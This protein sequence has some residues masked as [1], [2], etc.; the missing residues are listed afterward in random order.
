M[1]KS[2]FFYVNIRSYLANDS[3]VKELNEILDGYE[4]PLNEDVE[5]FLKYTAVEFAERNQSVSYLVFSTEDGALLG[6]F[7]IAIKA[8]TVRI[9]AISNTVS[10]KLSRI[11]DYDTETSSYTIPAFLIAQLG[12][13]YADGMNKRIEGSELLEM[14]WSVIKET[15]YAVGGIVAFLEAENNNELLNFYSV[16]NNFRKFDVRGSSSTGKELVQLLKLL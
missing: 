16:K 5:H 7:T 15:Q 12:K 14:A 6:Y 2:D 10:R 8:I 3:S 1:S 11:A 13:N 4:C 9:E